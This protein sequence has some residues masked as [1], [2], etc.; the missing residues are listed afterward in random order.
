M[1]SAASY[2]TL[3]AAVRRLIPELERARVH[4]E[5]LGLA[6]KFEDVFVL[7]NEAMRSRA[8][9]EYRPDDI[10]QTL[11]EFERPAYTGNACD[12]CGRNRVE[13]SCWDTQ[14]REICEKCWKVQGSDARVDP[15][16]SDGD[17][18]FFTV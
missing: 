6:D 3:P 11:S 7:G 13:H 18:G 17:D 1:I 14:S 4:A 12:N 2:S 16:Q 8:G 10:L 15:N 9:L 5:M